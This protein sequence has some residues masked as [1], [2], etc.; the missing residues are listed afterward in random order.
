MLRN[1]DSNDNKSLLRPIR[2]RFMLLEIF[3]S[4]A[5]VLVIY[6]FVLVTLTIS[7]NCHVESS[8][9]AYVNR[10]PDGSEWA[11]PTQ[12]LNMSLDK[13][14]YMNSLNNYTLGIQVTES[15]DIYKAYLGSYNIP[16]KK[17]KDIV[18]KCLKSGENIGYLSEYNLKYCYS[19]S[20]DYIRIALYDMGG[21][22]H[23][24][25]LF[26][27][28]MI[29]VGIFVALIVA[30]ITTFEANWL[31]APLD[32]SL[33]QQKQFTADASH[34]LKTPLT[35]IKANV[36]ILKQHPDS[37][38]A[39]E[40]KWINYIDDESTKMK[41][42]IQDMLYLAKVDALREAPVMAPLDLTDLMY[43]VYLPFESLAFENGVNIS[44]DIDPDLCV[45][46][47]A[48]MLK[49]LFATLIE[50][51][52]KYAGN[53]GRVHVSAF[54]GTDKVTVSI[55]NTGDLIP[56]EKLVHLFERFYRVDESRN[57]KSGGFGLGLAIA[58]NIADQHHAKLE[59]TSDEK[60]GNTFRVVFP[61]FDRRSFKGED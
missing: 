28:L 32:E 34:E 12:S 37:T 16:E 20:G 27:I 59:V 49:R 44:S 6:I 1:T 45:T 60:T 53:E 43:E 48:N 19:A 13:D 52:L 41:D 56:P 31:L 54:E 58:K 33:T 22:L 25:F 61:A 18:A 50:N 21:F 9:M 29:F 35:V 26:N 24:R 10:S 11:P 57:G 42:L 55:N 17:L 7:Y 5:I 46:G 2:D 51:A 15:G 47:D 14:V 40:M 36:D 3:S 8:L 30:V 23:Y 38:V 4:V 39:D